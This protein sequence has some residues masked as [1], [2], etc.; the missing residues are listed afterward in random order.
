MLSILHLVKAP[1]YGRTAATAP[2]NVGVV[3]SARK[4]VSLAP[5]GW[6]IHRDLEVEGQMAGFDTPQL[7]R[8]LGAEAEGREELRDVQVGSSWL[9][10]ILFFFPQI[11]FLMALKDR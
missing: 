8:G 11:C 5:C 6:N 1:T 7:E 10:I 2:T 9:L 4:S 3:A